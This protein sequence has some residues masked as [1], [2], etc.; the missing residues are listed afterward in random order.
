MTFSYS[1]A[2]KLYDLEHIAKGLGKHTRSG[3][4]YSCLCPVHDD[5]TPSLSLSIGEKGNLLVYCFAG[6]SFEDILKEITDR[7]L[8]PVSYPSPLSP[9]TKRKGG[10]K[11]VKDPEEYKIPPSPPLTLVKKPLK[12]S[13]T[14]L[15]PVPE[16]APIFSPHTCDWFNKKFNCQPSAFYPYR[17]AEGQLLGY[18]VR[19]DNVQ[20]KDGT[21]KKETRPYVYAQNAKGQKMWASMGLPGKLPLYNLPDIAKRPGDP[22]LIVEGEK[23]VEA[24]KDMFPDYVV[25]TTMF[26][27]QSPKQTDWLVL[28][29]RDVLICPDFD[30]A[31]QKYGDAVYALCK[32]AGVKSL[33]YLP[34][35]TIAKNL[36]GLPDIEKGY[37]LADAKEDGLQEVLQNQESRELIDPL[38]VPYRSQLDR[39]AET[40]PK[41]FRFDERGN[42]T[43][44]VL[45][46]NK[47]TGEWEEIWKFLC[48]Y[49]VVTHYMRDGKS[50]GWAR[51]LKILDKDGVQKEYMM[52]MSLLAGDGNILKEQL[53]SL[54]VLLN[55]GATHT[56]KNYIALSNPK[57]RARA[58]DKTGWDNN[59]YILSETKIYRPDEKDSRRQE[60]LVLNLKNFA[61]VIE[62]KGTLEEWQQTLG[63]YA[64]GNSRLQMAI[65]ASLAGPLLS[66]LEEENFVLHYFGSSSIGKS[67]TLQVASSVWGKKVYTWRTTDNA[68]ESLARSSH[69]G[70]LIFDELSQVTA[71]VADALVYMVGNGEGKNRANKQG[72]IRKGVEFKL[73]LMSSGEVGLEAKLAETKGKKKVKGGQSVRFIEI[74]ADA[75]KGLGI[76]ENIH[77]FDNAGKFADALKELTLKYRGTLIDAW[78][79]F[80][81]KNREGVIDRINSL[82]KKWLHDNL[83]EQADGQVERVRLKIALLAAAGEYAISQGFLPWKQGD[84]NQACTQVFNDWLGQRGG[85]ESHEL[86]EVEN[87]LLTFMEAHGSSRFEHVQSKVEKDLWHE[88]NTLRNQNTY[89]TQDRV[90]T[91]KNTV[92]HNRVGFRMWGDI[93]EK[94]KNEFL[95]EVSDSQRDVTEPNGVVWEYYF[96]PESFEQEILQGVNK[97]NAL[98]FLAEKG[99]IETVVEKVKDSKDKIRYT[100]SLPITGYGQQRLYGIS[101]IRKEF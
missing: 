15:I 27:A 66:L 17:N 80:L 22:V 93:S 52:P 81:V 11:T 98:P 5:H 44:K 34:I 79:D 64:I 74:P 89:D 4:G 86:L 21:T 42:I 30:E 88:V 16:D 40:L 73:I 92:T 59:C 55:F 13:Y 54:G 56:L 10:L 60:R 31:G 45:E 50:N 14:P 67:I 51:I 61:P 6:C 85:L 70:L 58:F 69:D 91:L 101:T 71:E 87:R 65:M 63:T 53:L 7:N 83:L 33:H 9:P 57:A 47:E 90:Q 25:T 43:Y 96:L 29:E 68:A 24:A 72:D 18:M 46:K 12:E 39:E 76:F 36:L 99:L 2:L 48:S 20:Q 62:Q 77:N 82:R 3:N 32:E 8:L 28:K 35:Q 37:D 100:K 49:V 97:K 41:D 95:K 75:E 84:A 38:I 26:G 78:L 19:W 1:A 23:T 94:A